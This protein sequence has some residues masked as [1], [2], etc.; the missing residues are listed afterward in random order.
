VVLLR[1]KLGRNSGEAFAEFA[2]QEQAQVVTMAT[3]LT[4]RQAGT[5]NHMKHMGKRY[6]EVFKSN[7][8]EL[9]KFEGQLRH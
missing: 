8:L 7:K 5:R 6:I 3:V 1:D 9:E 4:N 2:T